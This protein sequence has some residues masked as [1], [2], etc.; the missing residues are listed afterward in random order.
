[1]EKRAEDG[2]NTAQES[3]AR[4]EFLRCLCRELRG[5]NAVVLT[6]CAWAEESEDPAQLRQWLQ[7]AAAAMRAQ[8][9]LLG[10]LET[11]LRAL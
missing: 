4:A 8:Q 2:R 10:T 9:E 11:M 7:Q 6:H 3:A 5:Q 1:M